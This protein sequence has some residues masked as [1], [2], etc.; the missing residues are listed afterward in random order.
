MRSL[1]LTLAYDGTAYVG[2]QRQENGVSVQEMVEDAFVPLL[3]GG[4]DAAG[5]R[6]PTVAGAGRTDA[7]VHALG[8]VASVNVEIDVPALSIQRALNAR[9]PADIRVL[10]VVDARP[11]F[12][13]RHHATG[14]LYRYRV[15]TTPV[16]SPFE[17][18]YAWHAPE[19][20]DLGAMRAAAGRLVGTHDFAS[21]QARGATV[22][23][24]VRTIHRLDVAADGA[25]GLTIEVE[26]D[27]F[28]RHMV[29][30]IAGTLIE[31]A[32]GLR[33]PESLDPMIARRDRQAGGP[34]AP[35]AG[36]TL[37]A[38]RYPAVC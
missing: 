38:V 17:R 32:G 6:G 37:V 25:G 21:F 35:A 11:G 24:T 36:L 26:G 23:H 20:R 31:V 18:L 9:L 7:G 8:Q 28:L 27:G 16:L 22:R 1:K 33:P 29:R 34:T 12:H 19:A 4:N 5:R 13:A 14:K 15:V 3:C 30:A 10:G 2:W